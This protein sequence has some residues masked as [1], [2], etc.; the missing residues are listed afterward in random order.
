M[1]RDSFAREAEACV[2][3]PGRMNIIGEHTDYAGGLSL[4]A[5]VD[6]GVAVA[7][8]RSP[9]TRLVSEAYPGSVDLHSD[10]APGHGWADILLGTLLQVGLGGAGQRVNV[11]V[12]ADLQV[13]AGMSSSAAV[14]VAC[15]LAGLRLQGHRRSLLEVASLC[16][17]AEHD[18]LGVPSGLMDQVAVLAGRAGNAILFDAGTE[19]YAE[20]PLPP[21]AAWLVCPSGLDRSLRGSGYE[22]RPAEAATALQM[23]RR[24]LPGL[25]SLATLGPADVE[26]LQLPEPLNRR[27]RH[28]VGENLRVRQ[29]VACLEAGRLDALGELMLAS[30]QSLARDCE[31]STPQL[32]ALVEEAMASGCLGARLMG[33]GFGGS[34]IALVDAAGADEVASELARR[35]G[36]RVT[37]ATGAA[38]PVD[39]VRVVDGAMPG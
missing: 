31:V 34:I 10:P 8:G 9:A 39:R 18:F 22:A 14:A 38:G 25:E 17:A 5:A 29:A 27:A 24:R 12:A 19:R 20:V 7:L 36:A 30:H 2:S 1:F 15:A 16:R 6:R 26:A 33:A 35:A 28:I 11:A 21:S 37:A 4:P 23:A 32:D 13:G 3:A